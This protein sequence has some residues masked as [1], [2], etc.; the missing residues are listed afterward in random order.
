[1]T[2]RRKGS[3]YWVAPLIVALATLCALELTNRY[4]PLAAEIVGAVA[5][6]VVLALFLRPLGK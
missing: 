2:A 6:V 1:M 5:L 3:G 4:S